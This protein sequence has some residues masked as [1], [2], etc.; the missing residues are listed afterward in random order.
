MAVLSQKQSMGV[1]GKA[2]CGTRFRARRRPRVSQEVRQG[3]EP[4]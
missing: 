2:C 4:R 1:I 3:D